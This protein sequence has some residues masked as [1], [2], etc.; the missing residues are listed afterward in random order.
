MI[1]TSELIKESKEHRQSHLVLSEPCLE[2]GGISTNHKGILAEFLC[3]DIPYR[4]PLLL[5]A[6]NNDKC[7]NP[8]HLYWGTY[9]ENV[10]DAIE[11]GT[12]YVPPKG[13]V[14]KLSEEQRKEIGL[15]ISAS[16]KGKPSNNQKGINGSNTG[17]VARGYTYTRKFKQ[18]WI[19]NGTINTR[20]AEDM[21]IPEGFYPGMTIN[22]Q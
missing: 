5:H 10:K 1:L 8:R 9:E 3:T 20:I 12:R 4:M 19:T 13:S 14:I 22:S 21:T 17:K 11:A 7:S 6:C 18:K 15:K 2:R 16:K